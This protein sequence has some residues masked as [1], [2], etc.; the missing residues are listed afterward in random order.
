MT[1]GFK[2]YLNQKQEFLSEESLHSYY[3]AYDF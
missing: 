3:L 2:E 1:I